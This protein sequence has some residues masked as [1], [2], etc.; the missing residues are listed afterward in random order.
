MGK[1]MPKDIAHRP[2]ISRTH[3]AIFN[4]F[5]LAILSD[6]EEEWDVWGRDVELGRRCDRILEWG[7][8]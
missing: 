7:I 5:F 2:K 3:I 8:R 4:A 1:A 6:W